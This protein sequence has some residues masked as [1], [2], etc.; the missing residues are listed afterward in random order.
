VNYVL[1]DNGSVKF[2][3][4]D[5]AGNVESDTYSP[6][7]RGP[8]G[9]GAQGGG[10]R[11]LRNDPP[12]RNDPRPRNDP[13][14][15]KQPPESAANMAKPEASG[16]QT[17]FA[18]S[19][20]AI[21]ADGMLPVEF[22]CD[23]QS[24]SPPIQWQGAPAGTKSFALSLWL[25]APDQEKSYWL[26]YN[27]PVNIDHLDKNDNRTGTVGLNDEKRAAY[28]PMCSKGPGE[29]KYHVTVYALSSE[30]K[31]AKGSDNRASFLKA[32]KNVSLAETTLDFQ[33]ERQPKEPT[34]SC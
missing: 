25:T 23:G 21:G 24:V 2:D 11:P 26:V 15:S 6:R 10:D 4:V 34:T 7:Q 14:R 13:T 33:Y 30:L 31:L 20:S 8:G 12:P 17:G 9:G 29:K 18:V 16:A 19:S 1:N 27:I 3:F 32:I 5:G 22:T 28:D